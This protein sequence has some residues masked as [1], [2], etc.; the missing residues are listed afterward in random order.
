MQQLVDFLDRLIDETAQ[1]IAPFAV[2]A[3]NDTVV[4]VK[5]RVLNQKTKADGSSTGRYSTTPVPKYFLYG[6]S[7][8]QG[9]EKKVRASK[10]P[11]ESY[12]FLRS[13]NNLQTEAKDYSFSG[14]M[15]AETGVVS[16]SSTDS[17]IEVVIGGQSPYAQ[18]LLL[19]NAERDDVHLLEL[20]QQENTLMTTSVNERWAQLITDL[21]YE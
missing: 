11:Y 13:A 7:T 1:S 6:R 4:L 14:R 2:K 15:W 21:A 12:S 17:S 19:L 9:A 16:E 20:S 10:N 5:N 18:R 8:S 3:A